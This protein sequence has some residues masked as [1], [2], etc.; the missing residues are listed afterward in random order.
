ML[1][2]A[3]RPGGP[4]PLSTEHRSS[5]TRIPELS[6]R[7]RGTPIVALTAYAT[8]MAQLLDPHVDLLLVGDS[9]GMVL[10]GL[11]DTRP[12]TLDMMIAHGAAVVRGSKRA[13]VIVDLPFGS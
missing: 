13:A 6:K 11:D 12:V 9:V 3:A 2:S 10:Y 8:P 7:K 4:I 1:L 5:R